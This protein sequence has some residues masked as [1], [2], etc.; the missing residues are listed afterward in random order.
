MGLNYKL[1]AEKFEKALSNITKEE[2]EEYF[3]ELEEPEPPKGWVSIEEYLPKC[4]AIDFVKQGYSTYK[5]MDKNGNEFE[6]FVCDHSI[7][8]YTAKDAGITHWW[9]P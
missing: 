7:W 9:N 1:L 6:S 8:Y 4:L 3:K 2:L 5:V